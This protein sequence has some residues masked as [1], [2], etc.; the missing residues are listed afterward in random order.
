[1]LACVTC[2]TTIIF[3]C[4][5]TVWCCIRIT[6]FQ[7]NTPFLQH[8]KRS[9]QNATMYCKGIIWVVYCCL[10]TVYVN[11]RFCDT[12]MSEHPSSTLVVKHYLKIP[13]KIALFCIFLLFIFLFTLLAFCGQQMKNFIVQRNMCPYCAYGIKHFESLQGYTTVSE[14]KFKL[15][16]E[17]IN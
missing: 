15:K 14:K 8:Y 16:N 7:C 5:I 1:M 12:E 3:H 2:T 17:N 10:L 6:G 9:P 13:F 4:S 11:A